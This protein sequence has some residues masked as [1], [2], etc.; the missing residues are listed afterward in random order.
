M[1]GD[2]VTWTHSQSPCTGSSEGLQT[3]ELLTGPQGS[4]LHVHCTI[5]ATLG[6]RSLTLQAKHLT[7]LGRRFPLVPQNSET[8]ALCSR[9][10]HG[11]CEQKRSNEI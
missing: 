9:L 11:N 3:L 10:L 5:P 6:H 1:L 8:Q 2:F 4:R 7:S